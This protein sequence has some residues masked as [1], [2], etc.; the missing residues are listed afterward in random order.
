[1]LSRQEILLLPF[2]GKNDFRAWPAAIEAHPCQAS[3]ALI[4]RQ[5]ATPAL[6]LLARERYMNIAL[7]SAVVS[8]SLRK[9]GLWGTLRRATEHFTQ[10]QVADDFDVRNGTD[11]SGIVP[12]WKLSISSPN[13]RFGGRYHASEEWE[14]AGALRALNEDLSPFTFV[15]L[16][17]GKGRSLLIAAQMGFKRVIGV[18]FAVQLAA[19]ARKNIQIMRISNAIVIDADAATFS[20]PQGNVVVFL[21]NPFRNAVVQRVV[22]N[23]EQP[24]AG[25]LYVVYSNPVCAEALDASRVLQRVGSAP[26][27]WLP[28]IIWKRADDLVASQQ[29]SLN[30]AIRA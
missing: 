20:L 7:V 17:C 15:D 2:A 25:N 5:L 28:T 4:R 10:T 3:Q 30:L 14:L 16:G 26:A 12:L 21:F 1:L 22:A 6:V 18:E 11:T 9:R 27:R 13:A 23:V 8:K 19:V 29:P 24:R